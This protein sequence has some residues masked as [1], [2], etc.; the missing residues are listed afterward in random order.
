MIYSFFS[1]S[2]WYII[3]PFIIYER[4]IK[5]YLTYY[6][7]VSQKDKVVSIGT[8]LPFIGHLR[9]ILAASRNTRDNKHPFIQTV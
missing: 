8:P 6:H 2:I 9:Q 5:A 4:V 1:F 3:I 7:Y